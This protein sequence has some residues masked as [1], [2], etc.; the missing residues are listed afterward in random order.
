MLRLDV[1]ASDL[2]KM[3]LF[4]KS[5]PY[6]VFSRLLEDGSAVPVTKTEVIKNTLSPSWKTIQTNTQLLCNGDLERP[7]LIEC[8]DWNRSGTPDFIGSFR[9]PVRAIV[10]GATFDLWDAEKADRRKKK[11]KPYTGSGRVVFRNVQFRREYSFLDF[12]RSGLELG[13]MV[14]IDFTASNGDPAHSNS[15]H[16]FDPMGFHQNA[17]EQ[18]IRSIGAIVEPYDT[19]KR[20]P[21][22]GFGGKLPTTGLVSHCFTIDPAAPGVEG[23][24]ASY[25]RALADVALSG[26]TLFEHIVRFAA[27][28]ALSQP[29]SY[30]ILLIMT[31]GAIHDMQQTVAA[32]VEASMLPLS[33]IIIGVGQANF[34]DMHTL[35]ADDVPLQAYGRVAER[36]IVQFVPF[37]QFASQ[38]PWVLAK[39]TCAE[40][41]TQVVQYMAK[42]GVTPEMVA[43][44]TRAMHQ[45]EQQQ[46]QP[47]QPQQQPQQQLSGPGSAVGASSSYEVAGHA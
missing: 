11:G 20:F 38:P 42:Q 13:F 16:Y 43:A 44:R 24:V 2:P 35:D 15:L 29:D 18:A 21:V 37:N 4:G 34:G 39:E 40:L 17:Y 33:I 28:T 10:P 25:R 6:L 30:W 47:S 14:A 31:D 1:A 32:I 8:F 22:L 19:D 12:V 41:P 36:D 27:Q 7:V 46:Q 5:D 23:M 9:A 3:D 45:F 26:P